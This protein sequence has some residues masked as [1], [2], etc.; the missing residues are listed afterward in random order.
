MNQ[1]IEQLALEI[2][3]LLATSPIDPKIK[4][5]ILD[6]LDT[7]P[8]DLVFRLK[9]ALQNERDEIDSVLFD[10]ELFMKEQDERWKKLEEDQQKAATA[11]GD[12]LFDKLKD[13]P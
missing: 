12:E 13:Q 1:A 10:I 5:L 8:E 9:D 2:G 6:H 4:T 3:E 7:M 11:I